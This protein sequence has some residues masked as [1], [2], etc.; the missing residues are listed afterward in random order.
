MTSTAIA[1]QGSVLSLA[2]GS[3]TA[4]NI[5]GVTLGNPTVI[6]A[7]WLASIRP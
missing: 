7:W 4:K 5:T 6:T 3:G 1:S 2:T